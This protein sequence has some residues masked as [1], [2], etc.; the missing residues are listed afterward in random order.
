VRRR[1]QG[2][3]AEDEEEDAT[4][5]IYFKT[6]RYNTCNIGLKIDEMFETCV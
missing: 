5:P 1:H 2:E 4:H 6:P 3:A